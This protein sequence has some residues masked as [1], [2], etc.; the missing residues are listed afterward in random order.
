MKELDLLFKSICFG[1]QGYN[2][3]QLNLCIKGI[4]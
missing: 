3:T 4:H 1:G 2:N